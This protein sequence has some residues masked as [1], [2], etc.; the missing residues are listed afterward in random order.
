MGGDISAAVVERES[1]PA[2]AKCRNAAIVVLD[3]QQPFDSEE[4]GFSRVRI[5]RT[6]LVKAQESSRC[7]IRIRDTSRKISPGPTA[8]GGMG[9][10]MHLPILLIQQ[11]QFKRA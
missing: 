2:F 1:S 6:K 10:R 8:R 9:V 3:I 7:I 4:S 5:I 11:P